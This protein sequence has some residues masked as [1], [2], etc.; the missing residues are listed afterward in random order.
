MQVSHSTG[1]CNTETF[2]P[3]KYTAF[4]NIYYF[5]LGKSRTLYRAHAPCRLVTWAGS[6]GWR[7]L[8]S[9]QGRTGSG[10]AGFQTGGRAAEPKRLLITQTSHILPSFPAHEIS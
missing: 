10:R 8:P 9:W 6:E 7:T 3:V 2:D 4:C 1:E 5:S